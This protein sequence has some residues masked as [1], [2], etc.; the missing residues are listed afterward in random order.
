MTSSLFANVTADYE[1]KM[2]M[3]CCAVP[4]QESV[5]D[6]SRDCHKE[7]KEEQRGK[8]NHD[9]PMP[10]CQANL[11]ISIQTYLEIEAEEEQNEF[12]FYQTSQNDFYLSLLD[13]DLTYSIWH[14]PKYIS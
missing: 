7:S 10:E 8:C 4:V 12:Q 3:N 5:P 9:C 13:K 11:V 2:E 6:G 14:P 1:K